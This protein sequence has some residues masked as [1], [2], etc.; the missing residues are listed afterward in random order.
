MKWHKLIFVKEETTNIVLIPMYIMFMLEVKE[1]LE[2][3]LIS[4]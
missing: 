2:N 1:D 4:T 3:S